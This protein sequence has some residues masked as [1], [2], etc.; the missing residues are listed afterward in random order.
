[1]FGSI[2]K[3]EPAKEYHQNRHTGEGRY[4]ELIDISGC[5]IASGMTDPALFCYCYVTCRRSNLSL[6]LPNLI[7]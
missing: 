5:R 6:L 3:I 2:C 7:G 1:M 4:P